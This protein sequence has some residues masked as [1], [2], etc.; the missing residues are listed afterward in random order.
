MESKN[1]PTEYK[2]EFQNKME[3]EN[4]MEKQESTDNKMDSDNKRTDNK[5]QSKNKLYEVAVFTSVEN[6]NKCELI[7]QR[8]SLF[9]DLN[10]QKIVQSFQL[11]KNGEPNN[12]V[13]VLDLEDIELKD[14]NTFND[15][16]HAKFR[17]TEQIRYT[18]LNELNNTVS[19]ELRKLLADDPKAFILDCRIGNDSVAFPLTF[20]PKK[21]VQYSNDLRES[22][23]QINL[24]S[25]RAMSCANCKKK[26]EKLLHCSKCKAAR[27][28]NVECQKAD[29]EEHKKICTKGN[30][31]VSDQKYLNLVLLRLLHEHWKDL[32]LI[33]KKFNQNIKNTV[34]IVDV[35]N[36][37]SVPPINVDVFYDL[38]ESKVNDKS[39]VC[40]IMSFEDC[41]NAID[42]FKED[43]DGMFLCAISYRGCLTVGKCK[44]G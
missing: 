19:Q 11:I 30:N 39:L 24:L 41:G 23:E 35:N 28:C 25:S 13:V 27:Y 15:A 12:I 17:Q 42:H 10:Y 5:I 33:M 14:Q 8:M 34:L 9:L 7:R 31:K 20:D 6:Q 40:R 16:L 18:L 21:Q 32:S 37:H 29:W 22:H 2:M 36:N 38:V 44:F 4:K 26:P 3:F 43:M 1:E